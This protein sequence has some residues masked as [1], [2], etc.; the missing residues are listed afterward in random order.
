MVME[1]RYYLIE[2]LEELRIL[3]LEPLYPFL[4]VDNVSIHGS[5]IA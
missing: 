1:R 2:L 4:K 3:G 5:T